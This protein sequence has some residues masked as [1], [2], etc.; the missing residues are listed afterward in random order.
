MDQLG[1]LGFREAITSALPPNESAGFVAAG[2]QVTERLHLLERSVTAADRPSVTVP[3]AFDVM[4]GHKR[5]LGELLAVDARCFGDFWRLDAI[6][7]HDARTATTYA[8]F[9]VARRA[10]EVV[11]YAITGRQGRMGYLQRLAVDPSAQR[12]GLGTA[13][14]VD[15][16]RWLARWHARTVLVNTQESNTSALAL[17]DSLHFRIKPQGLTVLSTTLSS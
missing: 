12:T 7:V 5:D 6:G 14:V 3:A 17:Y 15:G 9:R 4:R 16:M 2:F 1:R 11:G 10:G 8:R 13:L